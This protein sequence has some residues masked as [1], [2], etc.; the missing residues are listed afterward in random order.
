MFPHRAGVKI[1]ARIRLC[2]GY[3]ARRGSPGH[4]GRYRANFRFTGCACNPRCYYENW[5]VHVSYGQITHGRF[6]HGQPDRN[7]DHRV[8]LYGGSGRRARRHP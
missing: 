8:H 6:V 5:L 4:V 2:A 1:I 7:V 3:P